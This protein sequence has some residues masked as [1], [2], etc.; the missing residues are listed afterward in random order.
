MGLLSHLAQT[1]RYLR[2]GQLKSLD[3]AKPYYQTSMLTVEG[4]GIL[5]A[6]ARPFDYTA[7]IMMYRS[8]VYAAATMNAEGVA[9]NPLRL[10]Q[11][12]SKG[13]SKSRFKGRAVN[14]RAK[15]YLRGQLGIKPWDGV[16]MKSAQWGD[17][18]E[19][20]IEDHPLLKLLNKPNEYETGV[21]LT[22]LR[23]LYGELTG[24]AYLQVVTHGKDQ[25]DPL[26]AGLPGQLLTMPSQWTQIAP[27]P[28]RETLILG[29]VY[30]K[31][32]AESY[33][34]APNEVI[35]FK[36]P[37]P[38]NLIYG[39]GKIEAGW[40][41]ISILNSNA[42]SDLA[43]ADN[44]ARPDYLVVAK[45]GATQDQ[46]N[47]VTSQ[48]NQRLRG[49][50]RSGNYAVMDGDIDIKQLNIPPKEY[51]APTKIIEEIEAIFGVKGKLHSSK[52][53]RSNSQ[54]AD[55]TWL[56][57]TIQPLC[58]HDEECLNTQYLPLWGEEVAQDML[59]A[60]DNPIP[61]DEK[62][63]LE[64]NIKKVLSGIRLVNEV[65]VEDGDEPIEGGDVPLIPA[66]LVK[67]DS[68]INPEKY[69]PKEGNDG[70]K[71][72]SKS[73]QKDGRDIVA[74]PSKA[75]QKSVDDAIGIITKEFNNAL[76]EWKLKTSNILEHSG[77]DLIRQIKS[78]SGGDSTVQRSE[79]SSEEDLMLVA[80]EKM[81]G[82]KNYAD[83]YAKACCAIDD[84]NC[85]DDAFETMQQS[86]AEME[87]EHEPEEKAFNLKAF[88]GGPVDAS[89]DSYEARRKRRN[90]L[91]AAL[92]LLWGWERG[93]L[94]STGKLP[95]DANEAL[96]SILLSAM[97]GES[98]DYIDGMAQRYSLNDEHIKQ[99][100]DSAAIKLKENADEMAA[101]INEVTQKRWDDAKDKNVDFP[102]RWFSMER[103][104][105][106]T[107]DQ[108]YL[109]GVL[110]QVVAS[111][112]A[113][114]V[115]KWWTVQDERVCPLCL[116]FDGQIIDPDHGPFPISDSHAGCR[117]A[118]SFEAQ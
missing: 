57:D 44:M 101:D 32:Q 42:A 14:G 18:F 83:M 2:T 108:L 71:Q 40:S 96:S 73:P 45:A 56:R 54:E 90:D 59:L 12:R 88:T 65:R 85:T 24:N 67:L 55:L 6:K 50:R 20:V 33:R 41:A 31:S 62:D 118:I 86:L 104:N 80:H 106:I 46:I 61:S 93:S 63:R 29:Y 114:L 60:Y 102:A 26:M 16:M 115:A 15:R 84:D 70:G 117:C 25:G 52:L 3:T 30:G 13:L 34:F 22:M 95:A 111:V 79:A 78:A 98:S 72:S 77:I 64:E 58:K 53:N 21:G 110:G 116:S 69:Q 89:Y 74:D 75:V 19:E 49:T 66:T 28:K 112:P 8:W 36:R 37:N 10:Y 87:M 1:F 97:T 68:V 51:G 11:R 92:L 27:D 82:F 81:I 103:A 99:A 43:F 35:H 94:Q 48:L 9:G 4:A 17:D 91:I 47:R 39:M 38:A 109:A 23:V 100:V 76:G 5:G 7:A 107:G 113:Q 105:A